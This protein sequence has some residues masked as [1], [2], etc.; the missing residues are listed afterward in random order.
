MKLPT[1]INTGVQSLGRYDANAP[2]RVAQAESAATRAWAGTI[3]RATKTFG[4]LFVAQEAAEE[5]LALANQ[6]SKDKIANKMTEQYMSSNAMV[7][8]NDPNAPEAFRQYAKEN[9]IK[10]P[11]RSSE[12]MLPVMQ[13]Q[14]KLTKEAAEDAFSNYSNNNQ[15]AASYIG[16][17][18][19]DWAS[20]GGRAIET[21]A[22]HR[23]AQ[24][25]AMSD[26]QIEQ[27]KQSLDLALVERIVTENVANGIIPPEEGVEIMQDATT[28]V[29]YLT[30]TQQIKQSDD[31]DQLEDFDS[32]LLMEDLPVTFEQRNQ[33]ANEVEAQRRVIEQKKAEEREGT[34]LQGQNLALSDQLTTAWIQDQIINDRLTPAGANTL[35]NIVEQ[36]ANSPVTSNKQMLS[37]LKG[38]VQNIRYTAGDDAT[39]TK[40]AERARRMARMMAYGLDSAGNKVTNP[41]ITGNDYN[42]IL[43]EINQVEKATLETVQYRQASKQIAV[44]TK[45]LESFDAKWEPEARAEAYSDFKRHLDNYMDYHGADADPVQFVQQ[46]QDRYDPKNYL[47]DNA[48]RFLEKWPELAPIAED[49]T[50]GAEINHK[51]LLTRITVLVDQGV[52]DQ[53]TANQMESDLFGDTRNVNSQAVIDGDEWRRVLQDEGYMQ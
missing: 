8:P 52:L 21:Q 15:M 49:V 44:N 18:T 6:I 39:V 27:A 31:L 47:Q 16:S 43:D 34:L 42:A 29:A 7:D 37:E 3:E 14:F 17:M 12:I 50:T 36:K 1:A 28:E 11:I 10:G 4:D 46:N 35:R 22:K 48:A 51:A 30:M 24:L 26:A 19:N 45:I 32:A 9:G 38:R 20:A 33:L 13:R 25:V 40:N 23:Q 5:K 41:T 53:F 2:L